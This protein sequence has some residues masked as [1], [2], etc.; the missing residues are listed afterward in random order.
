MNMVPTTTGAAKAVALVI[1]ELQGKFHG[2]AIRVPTPT[3]SVVDFTVQFNKGTTVEEVNKALTDASQSE[4]MKGYLGVSTDPVVSTD[5]T[6]DT[7]SSIVDLPLTINMGDDF[8]KIV[9]WYDN[10]WGYATRVGDLISYM[11][12]RM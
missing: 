11:L 8:F 10:E 6:G 3:V 12:K 4:K 1:P 7:H 5:F 2:Y 9:A